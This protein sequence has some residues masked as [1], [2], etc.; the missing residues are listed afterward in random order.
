ML[1]RPHGSAVCRWCREPLWYGIKEE[2]SGWKVVYSCY[3][4][5]GCGREWTTGI[6]ER[7]NIGHVDEVYK[8]G[9]SMTP[10]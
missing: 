3:E 2:P 5:N 9:R 1:L 8:I 6:V 7:A 4:K 10:E